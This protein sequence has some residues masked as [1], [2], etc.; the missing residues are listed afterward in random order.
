[1]DDQYI[2]K[3]LSNAI[4]VLSLFEEEP[5]FTIKELQEETHMNR[6]TLYRIL[7]T[8]RHQGVLELDPETGKY[9]L[10]MKIV[11]LASLLLQR[12][13][14]KTIA[15]PYLCRLRDSTLETVHLVV[16]S[17][18]LA[19]FVDKVTAKEDINMGSYIGWT[20][21]LYA[22][23]SG[24]LLLSSKED[25]WINSY[26]KK[27]EFS[28]YNKNTLSVEE[29]IKKNINEIRKRGYSTDSEEMVEGLT[30]YAAPVKN[31]IGEVIAAVSISGATSRMINNKEKNIQEL[32]NYTNQITDSI[33]KI[34]QGS[35]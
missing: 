9:H 14:I 17:N 23:A 33:N 35:I 11:H 1:M 12:M 18:N 20:A 21:P 22:T 24:K 13:D 32:L 7:Y 30:C 4:D 25:E 34:P 16:L 27:T 6:T 15:H 5:S 28:K 3:T 8:L 19:A 2:L 10:G 26:L 31:H 29:V